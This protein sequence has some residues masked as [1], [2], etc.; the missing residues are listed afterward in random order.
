MSLKFIVISVFAIAFLVGCSSVPVE[1]TSVG[2]IPKWVLNPEEKDGIAVS[3][4]VAFSGNMSMDKQHA[5]ANARGSLA[6]RIETRVSVMDKT[7]RDKIANQD[8]KALQTGTTFSSVNK[9]LTQQ[10]LNGT[11]T[12]KTDI[13]KIA[14]KDQLCVLVA[15]G[16]D[17]TKAI[18]DQLIEKSNRRM[19]NAQKDL[20]FKEF[21]PKK[22]EDQLEVELNKPSK[23]NA[24]NN[25]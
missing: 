17:K 24:T 6:Q 9:Q 18:F 10:T 4:C 7:Y 2:E 21:K 22:A 23:T 8:P 13:L 1:N 20:L 3:A 16:Q 12:L 15:I 11:T 19:S 5:M 25:K 14:G